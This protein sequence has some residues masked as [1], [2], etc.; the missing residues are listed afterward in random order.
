[1]NIDQQR[2]AAVRTLE[3][4][5]Y[6]FGAEG[7]KQAADTR[8]VIVRICD[9]VTELNLALK[10]AGLK[11]GAKYVVFNDPEELKTLNNTIDATSKLIAEQ[12]VEF[13]K[14]R[15]RGGVSGDVQLM[16]VTFTYEIPF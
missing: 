16:G 1:M 2:Y 3:S 6:R 12:Q 11:R 7:W 5:G 8:D 10:A 4:L 15:G 13:R 14:M 9:A